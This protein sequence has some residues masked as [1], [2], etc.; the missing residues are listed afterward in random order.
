VPLTQPRLDILPDL[1]LLIGD[2]RIGESSAGY[3]GHVYAATGTLTASLPLAGAA[4]IDDAVAAA[5]DAFP[6]WAGTSLAERRNRLLALVEL[7]RADGPTLQA[8]Q[9]LESSVPSRFAASFPGAACDFLTY[10][11]GWADKCGGDVIGT[12]PSPALDY[13][14]DEPYGVV[15]IIVPWNAPMVSFAQIVGAAL[16]VGNTVVLKPPEAA[17]FTTLR[18]GELALQAGLPPGVVNVVPAGPIGGEALVRHPG[19]NKIHFTGS[20][21]TARKILDAAKEN[22]TPVGL[23]LGGKSAHLVFAD[24]NVRLAARQVLTG[25]VIN[26]GQGC[27]NGT[28]VLV[29]APVYEEVLRLAAGRVRHLSVGD[30][31]SSET[32]IGPVISNAACA[33]IIS[34][35]ERARDGGSG[36]LVCGGQRVTGDALGD[37]Y[38]IQPTIFADV[39]N[40]SE[41]ARE[42]IFGP[43][44]SF[45]K[46][47][48]DQEA[49][50]LAN[51]SQYGLAAY[52]H[53]NDLKRAHRVGRALEVGNVWVNG[54]EGVSPSM[55]FGGVKRSGYGRIG[56][57][58]GLKEFTR[59]KNLWIAL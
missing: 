17:P 6:V 12:W 4:E 36:R 21:A 5:R 40:A 46:F 33:R 10:Y 18:L 44:L 35:I 57:F 20:G 13:T 16:A 1:R 7:V 2:E 52:L 59:T 43:V 8:L 32:F 55:P 47:E 49:V 50:A 23:E 39:D 3:Y 38:F 15:G 34:V 19:V 25:L 48:N 31:F 45:M 51:D 27:A 28:R 30:P 42:E 11:A 22:L 54:F 41:L 26:S 29:E 37:G 24:T 14:I 58:A 56:G 53:T 9:T